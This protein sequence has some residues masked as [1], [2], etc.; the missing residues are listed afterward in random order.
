MPWRVARSTNWTRREVNRGPLLT[1]RAS[2][3]SCANEAKAASISR[4][5]RASRICIRKPI[6]RAAGS[7]S[8]KFPAVICAL[9][10]STSTASRAIPGTSSRSASNRVAPDGEKD[11][12]HRRRGLSCQCRRR[13]TGGRDESDSP[14]DEISGELRQS[15]DV[16]LCPTVFK[17]D[18]LAFDVA[19]LLEPF[20]KLAQD[21]SVALRRCGVEQ[22]NYWQL[23]RLRRQRPRSR[24]TTEQRDELASPHSI[25]SS[26][27]ASS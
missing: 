12:N 15:V 3:R 10:G 21:P 11:R 23:L 27:R 13:T 17:G 26:A 6:V 5:L 20:T 4:G 9:L 25:T 7:T 22:P 14:P 19:G 2:G 8:F 24:R 18:V 16:I 1:N